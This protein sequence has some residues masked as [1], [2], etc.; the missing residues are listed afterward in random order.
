MECILTKL[1]DVTW[2]EA[3]PHTPICNLELWVALQTLDVI[4]VSPQALYSVG[5]TPLPGQYLV[6]GQAEGRGVVARGHPIKMD[7]GV[8]P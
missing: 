5:R 7:C 3:K 2:C 8:L 6:K 4:K 1:S